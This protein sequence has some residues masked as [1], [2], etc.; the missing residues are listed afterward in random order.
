MIQSFS[1]A[2]SLASSMIPI[3]QLKGHLRYNGGSLDL[4]EIQLQLGSRASHRFQR[5]SVFTQGAIERYS[6]DSASVITDGPALS[7]FYGYSFAIHD[8]NPCSQE[9]SS[10]SFWT[11]SHD[12]TSVWDESKDDSI[13]KRPSQQS[14]EDGPSPAS[15]PGHLEDIPDV[16]YLRSISPRI[17]IVNLI[18]T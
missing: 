12:E 7:E 13:A 11:Q 5:R 18:V 10:E 14:P 3:T 15:I 2:A 1:T 9:S 4:W 16:A 17:I 6:G 8:D